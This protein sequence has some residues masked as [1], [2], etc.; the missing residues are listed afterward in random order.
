MRKVNPNVK[1]GCRGIWQRTAV[2]CTA[3]GHAEQYGRCPRRHESRSYRR[4]KLNAIA[5][6]QKSTSAVARQLAIV[7]RGL[8]GCR[9]FVV[10][11]MATVC[12]TTVLRRGR[13]A[14]DVSNV[15]VATGAGVDMMPAATQYRMGGGGDRHQDDHDVVRHIASKITLNRPVSHGQDRRSAYRTFTRIYAAPTWQPSSLG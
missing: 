7:D 15:A 8:F 12:V 9:A 13:F 5:A 3:V 2:H 11:R 10:L 14:G 4:I 1:L 6:G